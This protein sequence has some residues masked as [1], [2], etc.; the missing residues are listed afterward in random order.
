MRCR[1]L[2][3]AVLFLSVCGGEVRADSIKLAGSGQMI[4]LVEQLATAY[5]KKFP[6]DSVAVNQNSLGQI[7]GVMAVNNGV[8]DIAMS[9]RPLDR[10]EGALPVTAYEIARVNGL[11]V[12]GRSLPVKTLTSLQLCDIYAGRIKNWKQ[13]GGP[14][15]P[16]VVLT[17]P[18][19]DSTKIAVRA[20]LACFQSLK[21]SADVRAMPKVKDMVAE[22]TGKPNTIGMLDLV[23]YAD[24]AGRLTVFKI[25]NKDLTIEGASPIQHRYHLV[26]GKNRGETVKRFLQYV[27]SPE[28]QAIIKKEKAIPVHF[29][30]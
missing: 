3:L 12:G 17:R 13:V 11:F 2:L 26:L 7:G 20:G 24:V 25:D 29:N 30:L 27:N 10:N 28:G 8:I 16:I 6:K 4:A 1:A 22:L 14:D 21:E 15:A 5:M 9:A 18:E 23:S 19:S